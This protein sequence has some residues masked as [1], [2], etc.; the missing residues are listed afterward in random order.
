MSQP[1]T[2]LEAFQAAWTADAVLSG[3]VS[4]NRVYFGK[5]PPAADV[6]SADPSKIDT[7]YVRVEKPE[8]SPQ[9]RSNCALYNEETIIVHLWTD[10]A[11]DGDQI[12]QQIERVFSY[13]LT[14]NGGAV[15][16]SRFRPHSITQVD[17]PEISQWETVC[18]FPMRT[19]QP[20][21]DYSGGD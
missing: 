17:Q 6:S 20:R 9:V 19:W 7:P 14:W 18:Q 3:L 11:D 13:N 5:V 10:N 2:L 16:D 12:A 1:G 8:G 21:P 15:I 4:D